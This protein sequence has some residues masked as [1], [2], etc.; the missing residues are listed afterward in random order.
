MKFGSRMVVLAAVLAL[1]LGAVL[2]S[3][4]LADDPAAPNVPGVQVGGGGDS[5]GTGL[6]GVAGEP[7]AGRVPDTATPLPAP[8]VVPQP[9]P[10][11]AE[12][13]LQQT[14][15]VPAPPPVIDDDDWSDDGSDDGDDGDDGDDDG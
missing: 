11:A 10:P 8:Q 7:N 1:P 4:A 2:G 5:A 6:P 13:P 12:P 3:Y 9:A 14:R 15:V